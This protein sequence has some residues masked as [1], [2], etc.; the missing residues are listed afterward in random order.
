MAGYGTL[1]GLLVVL[2]L[3]RLL[4]TS[5]VTLDFLPQ[6]VPRWAAL[7]V[8]LAL[9]QGLRNRARRGPRPLLGPGACRLP[10]GAAGKLFCC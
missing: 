10:K 3:V 9:A 7:I 2:L 1:L 5:G 4:D 6:S 8:L